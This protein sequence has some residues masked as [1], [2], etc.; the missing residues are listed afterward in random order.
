[1]LLQVKPQ[2]GIVGM[3][4]TLEILL[5]QLRIL[6]MQ[7]AL[8]L[9]DSQQVMEKTSTSQQEKAEYG[10]SGKELIEVKYRF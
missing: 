9:I 5:K 7:K 1:M 2:V 8:I 10:L 6:Q 4:G 3:S